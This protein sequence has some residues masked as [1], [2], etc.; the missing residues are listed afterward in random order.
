MSHPDRTGTSQRPEGLQELI[1]STSFGLTIYTVPYPQG[2]SG[3]R[4]HGNPLTSSPFSFDKAD[5]SPV[6]NLMHQSFSDNRVKSHVA[7]RTS[8]LSTIAPNAHQMDTDPNPPPEPRRLWASEQGEGDNLLQ[9]RNVILIQHGLDLGFTQAPPRTGEDS[10]RPINPEGYHGHVLQ[11]MIATLS[12]DSI[13]HMIQQA[14]AL[15][16]PPGLTAPTPDTLHYTLG[17]HPSHLAWT[18]DRR[19]SYDTQTN[20]GT[21]RE[22]L[23][24][25]DDRL[26]R[27]TLG[28]ATI[29][30]FLP[31]PVPALA[32]PPP[33]EDEI[34]EVQQAGHAEWPNHQSQEP[35]L[36]QEETPPT[37]QIFVQIPDTWTQKTRRP[38]FTQT[39]PVPTSLETL[40]ARLSALL[41]IPIHHLNILYGGK[42]L[43]SRAPL[44]QQGVVKDITVCLKIGSLLGGADADMTDSPLLAG[45]APTPIHRPAPTHSYDTQTSIEEWIDRLRMSS[46]LTQ[47]LATVNMLMTALNLTKEQ[48]TTAITEALNEGDGDKTTDAS[49]F[50]EVSDAFPDNFLTFLEAT[51]TPHPTGPTD[52][53]GFADTFKTFQG[54]IT[55]HV[56]RALNPAHKYRLANKANGKLKDPPTGTLRQSETFTLSNL[57]I[58]SVTPLITALAEAGFQPGTSGQWHRDITFRP[59]DHLDPRMGT[60]SATISILR[61]K[62]GLLY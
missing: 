11:V 4:S 32:I 57:N 48:A 29:Y 23:L 56:E 2:H 5:L 37:H 39:I 50:E 31:P 16:Y 3:L 10:A 13:G 19:P 55:R 21:K 28:T 52:W 25:H 14:L 62:R 36:P 24:S 45:S 8:V 49:R 43:H 30:A 27:I 26:E 34:T 18:H 51:D 54:R 47:D 1:Q 38:A 12:T 58:F 41:S 7:A 53:T 59:P 15:C 46:P 61:T 33:S 17:E 42:L 40:K 60:G 22:I 6:F 9:W 20:A 35:D 44:A